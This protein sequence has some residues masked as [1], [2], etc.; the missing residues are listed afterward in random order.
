MINLG[1]AGLGRVADVH[2]EAVVRESARARVTAVCDVR[3]DAVAGRAAGWGAKGYAAYR[4]MLD[5]EKLDAVCLLVP[6]D[7]HEEYVGL[8]AEKGLPVFL[9]KPLATEPAAGRR[10]VEV[11]RRRDVLLMVAHNGLFHPAFERMVELVKGGAIGRPL[12]AQAK[13]TQWLFFKEWDFRLSRAKTGGGAWFDCAGHL[14][15]RLRELL[16]EVDA[17]A[18]LSGNLVRAEMEGEDHAAAV[19]RYASG[20]MAQVLVSYGLRLPGYEHDWPNGCEQSILLSGDRGAIEYSICPESRLRL[21]SEVEGFRSPALQ[22]WITE[23]VPQGFN[24]SFFRQMSHFLDC[25]E[26]KAACRVTGEDA[27]ATVETLLK[28]YDQAPE[29]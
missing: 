10:M 23:D 29:R 2:H 8:A 12:F 4:E 1:F 17:L 16:G 28:F 5:R 18:G 25:L 14:V 22:G 26:G 9:E 21:F 19:L 6:H 3:P 13:S 27:L 15:Y 20:A 7:L 24:H 11:C